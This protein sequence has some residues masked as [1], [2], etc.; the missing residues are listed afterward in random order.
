MS[1]AN[2]LDWGAQAVRAVIF[3]NEFE[4]ARADDLYLSA[5]GQ[6]PTGYQSGAPLAPSHAIGS[7]GI[8]QLMLQKLAGRIDLVLSPTS[9]ANQPGR[10]VALIL[11]DDVIGAL[12]RIQRASASLCEKA[13][14]VLRLA[15]I[16]D[17]AKN[18]RDANELTSIVLNTAGV[19]LPE[20]DLFDLVIQYSKRYEVLDK[21]SIK[22]NIVYRWS[23][24]NFQQF[25]IPVMGSFNSA[26][27]KPESGYAAA[28][29]LDVNTIPEITRIELADARAVL[30][31]IR[32][33]IESIRRVVVA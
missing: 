5:F 22:V 10:T 3:S 27:V 26:Q 17:L 11:I 15:L 18:V 19:V 12:D 14:A 21:P 2:V 28:L 9:Q 20:K 8:W 7:D 30:I 25:T 33:K 24:I 1:S 31:R 6:Q 23:A 4:A 32:E 29:T 16:V 13:N